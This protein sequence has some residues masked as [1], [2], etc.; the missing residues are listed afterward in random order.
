VDGGACLVPAAAGVCMFRDDGADRA[1]GFHYRGR[2]DEALLAALS[3]DSPVDGS[4]VLTG[5]LWHEHAAAVPLYIPAVASIF[6]IAIVKWT[7]AGSAATSSIRPGRARVRV[8]FLTGEMTF[9][10]IRRPSRASTRL[11]SDPARIR[12][13]RLARLQAAR[14]TGR[15]SAMGGYPRSAVDGA[16]TAWSIRTSSDRSESTCRP[17]TSTF[18]WAAFPLHRRGSALLF[19]GNVHLFAKR[20]ITWEIR[21]PI[22]LFRSFGDG[23]RGL[24]FGSGLSPRRAVPF[25]LGR[26]AVGAFYMATTRSRRPHLVGMILFGLGCGLLSYLLRFTA[27]FR[28]G[29]ALILIMNIFVPTSTVHRSRRFV[30]TAEAAGRDLDCRSVCA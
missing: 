17:A 29:F 8:L 16:L 14:W 24:R 6:A 5:L 10:A 4:A 1:G 12:Q 11:R 30:L 27:R 7:F 9:G 15:F 28:R 2:G 3:A 26:I 18:S 25:F 23:I 13:D 21:W 20:I 22:S 19:C